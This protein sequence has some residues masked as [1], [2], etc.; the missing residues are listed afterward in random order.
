MWRDRTNLYIS[1]RQ[2]YSHRPTKRPRFSSSQ[3][4]YQDEDRRGLL[5]SDPDDSIALNGTNSNNDTII[6]MDRLPPRWADASD[7]V[8]ELLSDITRMS[9]KL[10]KLHA[11]HVLPGFDDN[12]SAEEGEIE[13]LTTDIT[14]KF[15]EC[16]SAIKRIERLAQG[17]T[18]AEEVMAK[19]I[20]ISLA[21]KVQQSSTAFR[22]KQAAYLKR[23]RGLSGITPP[24]E[25]SGSPN[26]AFMSTTLLDE[27]NDISYSRS[28]LQQSL[29]LTS[30]DNAIVQREREIT[31]IA[32]GI[33]E[34]A[35]IFKELQ[36]M[37]IDQGTLLDRID[38]N[39]E[40]MKTNVKEAQKELV[41]ASGY[42]KKTT[43]R[44]AMLLLVICIVG[45]IILLTLKPRRKG[46]AVPDVQHPVL[47]PSKDPNVPGLINPGGGNRIN[48]PGGDGQTGDPDASAVRSTIGDSGP[49][50]PVGSNTKRRIKRRVE[51]E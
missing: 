49:Y 16:Q 15:Y 3:P 4:D 6:E 2:S 43:K 21:T 48:H 12:R 22:K 9:Q 41:V 32:N 5:T 33:L 8:T 25:R 23:L 14:T 27:E 28:A 47:P 51:R 24:I 31:D 19:N 20:Q 42:Q 10:D 44:K 7:T 36:T 26:P 13:H 30:N 39:V 46:G 45:V 1:Y 17:G 35:D 38:Y 50:R 37:V 34:L 29:T 40:M 11:K 18:R